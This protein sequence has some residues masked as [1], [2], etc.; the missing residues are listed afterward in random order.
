MIEFY[1]PITVLNKMDKLKK[2][3]WIG[4]LLL[5]LL[6]PAGILLPRFFH[7]GSAW[8]EWSAD[9]VKKEVGY[10]PKGMKKTS[11]I[12]KAPMPEYGNTKAGNKVSGSIYY[13]ISGILGVGIISL[14]TWVLLKYY[15][16]NE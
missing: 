15:R 10:E 1:E 13:M 6:T 12:W 3:L 2:R 5:C 4:L 8:G 16:K 14:A 9:E 11:E 7:A